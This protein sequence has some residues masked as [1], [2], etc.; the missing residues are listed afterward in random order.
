[1]KKILFVTG[2]DTGVGKT[3]LTSLLLAFLRGQ[4]CEALA[5]KPYCSGS[6]GDARL[7]HS[8]EKECLTIDEVNPFY[9]DKPMAPGA[10]RNGRP[11]VPLSAALEH[12][13]TAADR[14]DL[15]LVEGV[16]GLLAPLGKD[17]DVRDLIQAL[18]CKT[19]VV[20]ANRLGTINHT[21]LTVEAL[22]AAGI[23]EMAIALMEVRRPDISSDNNA[24]ILQELLAATPLFSL[25]Y[26]GASASRCE[27]VKKNAFFLKKTLAP[28]VWGDILLSVLSQ[29]NT[30]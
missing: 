22:R 21:L 5:I 26:L 27:E 29:N 6:R 28:L 18:D 25:P 9:F 11:P 1:M 23:D 30:E 19:I 13:E 20:S 14:C 7:L 8:L 24:E 10:V 2:T 12:I 17:Y 3:V 15:L 16:G 4:G